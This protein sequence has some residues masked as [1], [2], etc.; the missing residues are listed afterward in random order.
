MVPYHMP[1]RAL[2]GRVRETSGQPATAAVAL[3]LTLSMARASSVDIGG[4]WK[5]SG[6][7]R[8]LNQLRVVPTG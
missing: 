1:D 6:L 8:A 3:F 7:G 2:F 5:I 4:R